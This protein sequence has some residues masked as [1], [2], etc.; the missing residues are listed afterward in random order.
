MKMNTPKL[1]PVFG[2]ISALTYNINSR[3][4]ESGAQ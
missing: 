1:F 4:Y 3:M 2:L